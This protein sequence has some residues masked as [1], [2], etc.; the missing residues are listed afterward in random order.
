[1]KN[2]DTSRFSNKIEEIYVKV[3]YLKL[4]NRKTKLLNDFH[5][6]IFGYPLMTDENSNNAK[7]V[8]AETKQ[9]VQLIGS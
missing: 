6:S 7:R 1:M 5:Y 8:I 9:I 4:K 2:Y 3:V